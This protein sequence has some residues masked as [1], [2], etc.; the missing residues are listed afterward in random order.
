MEKSI[1]EIL[2]Y[3]LISFIPIFGVVS[4]FFFKR[5]YTSADSVNCE[6]KEDIKKIFDLIGGLAKTVDFVEVKKEVKEIDNKV[7]NLKTQVIEIDSHIK[8]CK[9]CNQ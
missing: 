9:G 6:I 8:Y 2:F 5:F 3:A 4:F 1:Y 7:N